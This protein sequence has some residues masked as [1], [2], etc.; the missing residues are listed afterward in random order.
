MEPSNG[1]YVEEFKNRNPNLW[2]TEEQCNWVNLGRQYN[3]VSQGVAVAEVVTHLHETS[4]HRHIL[5]HPTKVQ[6]G[7]KLPV[8]Y[9]RSYTGFF[10][11]D[12]K[13]EIKVD[14]D[15]IK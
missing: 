13:R 5:P 15:I 9:A 10:I 12:L 4:S 8:G 1:S 7:K 14:Q 11:W 3:V 2:W 6:E